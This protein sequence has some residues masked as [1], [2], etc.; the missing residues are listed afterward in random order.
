[1]MTSLQLLCQ[2]SFSCKNYDGKNIAKAVLESHHG[3]SFWLVLLR[4][5]SHDVFIAITLP[6]IFYLARTMTARTQQ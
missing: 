2:A 1:M 5:S 6:R 3:G 4:M